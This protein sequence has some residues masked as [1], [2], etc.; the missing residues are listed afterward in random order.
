MTAGNLS[1]HCGAERTDPE[2]LCAIHDFSEVEGG[3]TGM[4]G[5]LPDGKDLNCSQ[6]FTISCIF[7]I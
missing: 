5:I 2:T 4:V 3:K 7:I 1:G 6:N